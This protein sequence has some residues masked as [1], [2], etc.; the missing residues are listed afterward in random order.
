MNA[1]E[2]SRP[3]SVGE[4]LLSL[5]PCLLYPIIYLLA[6][7]LAPLFRLIHN[8]DLGIVFTL[9][10][11]GL[12]LTLMTVGWV[13]GFP[14][15]V[16]PYWGFV[17]LIAIYMQGFSGTIAGYQFDG[18][19]LVGMPLLGVGVV[20]TLWARG[21]RPV[22]ALFKSIWQDWTLLSFILYGALP[23]LFIAAYDEVRN[24]EPFMTLIALI[25][26][27]GAV[28]YMR[29]ESVW[30]RIASLVGGF[31][32]G[33]SILTVHQAIYWNGRQEFWMEKPG[34]WVETLAWTI[35]PGA[36]LMFFLVSPVLIAFLRWAISLNQAPKV[37]E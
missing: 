2:L 13:K 22:L 28:I 24:S 33:W 25:L 30:N 14:R 20:G 29:V 37:E 8:P 1:S 32:I 17:L 36:Y 16:F 3:A 18:N 26:A 12:L 23:L 6:L 9:I 21:F 4:T 10:V 11:V 34:S 5:V 35:R 7:L 27:G 31:T 15:W 19:W